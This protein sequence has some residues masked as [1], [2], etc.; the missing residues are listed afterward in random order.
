MSARIPDGPLV[1]RRT[2]LQLGG[3]L[4]VMGLLAACTGD[5][6][7]GPTSTATPTPTPSGPWTAPAEPMAFPT[8]FVWGS[9][10]SAFQVEGSTTVDGRGPSI[11][12]TFAQVPGHID[13]GST[14]DPAADHYRLWESDLDLMAGLGL[15]SYRFSVA[16]P[17]IVPTGSGATNQ[18]GIDFY[19]RLVDGLVDR[20]IR[21]AITLY[22]WDLPQPLQDA[23]GWTNRDTA[24]RFA[25]YAA[26]MFEALG[27]VD[28]TWLTINEPKTTA[29]VGYAGT[30]HAP[31]AGDADQG[32]AAVHHQLLAHGLA[33]QAF[34]ESG[35]V[36]EI[37]I[38]LNLQP[39]YPVGQAQ[40]PAARADSSEN[41]LFLDPVLLGT[42]PDDA[43]GDSSGQLHAD[44]A[45]FAALV[46]DGD[47]E[48]ISAPCDVL[49]VQYYGVGAVDDTGSWVQLYP[50]SPAGW[51]QVHA[52]GLYDLLTRLKR[53]YPGAPPLLITEN[54]IPDVRAGAIDDDDRVVFL[55]EHLQQAARAIGEG[56]DLRGYYAWSLLDNFEWARGMS[57]RWGIV[58]VDFD[59]QERTPKASA[60]WYSGVI[61]ANAVAP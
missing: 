53:D 41:R 44:P 25:E 31:G 52:E 7:P 4:A 19:R 61:T 33:V 39:I 10:T 45:T 50:T 43:I 32:A 60:N 3:G 16:W 59:T 42:Y 49:A 5:P 8:G 21:P 40:K 35:A 27:D 46:E 36:G 51:Q 1:D 55:R 22:H 17:R 34:R 54:G 47:L 57:Q 29:Y 38:A 13:D 2:V 9:A 48:I 58:H 12:D 56:V 18:R 23:G 11:W 6:G 26:V 14:G 37:G 30:E 15:T 20:G 28:A 24:T